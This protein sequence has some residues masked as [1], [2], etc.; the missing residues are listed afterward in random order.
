MIQKVEDIIKQLFIFN[1][2]LTNKEELVANMKVIG[3]LGASDHDMTEVMILRKK[4][5]KDYKVR[6]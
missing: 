3:N 6:H 5:H 4:R 1:F 2:V